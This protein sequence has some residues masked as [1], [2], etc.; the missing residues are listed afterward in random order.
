M[1]R[2]NN[3]ASKTANQYPNIPISQY[4]NIRSTNQNSCKMKIKDN[5]F[6]PGRIDKE[7]IKKKQEMARQE[8]NAAKRE[9]DAVRRENNL[10]KSRTS[11]E[12]LQLNWIKW[13]IT[14]MALGFTAYK[15]YYARIERGEEPLG[16]EL[17]G[18]GIGIIL[19]S[20]GLISLLIATLQ[21]KKSV[22]K[23]KLQYENMHYS[24]TLRLSYV[25]M[26]FSFL[27]L[28]MVIFRT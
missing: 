5:Q 11:L 1:K 23:L 22:Q 12:R 2:I 28:L 21:H 8:K 19:I 16:H 3:E 4:P 7:E 26:V 9:M 6:K 14:C 15:F 25:I 10:E 24:L 18:R 17:T 27:I 20:L 13:N